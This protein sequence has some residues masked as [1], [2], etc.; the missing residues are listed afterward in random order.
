V[1][2]ILV[3]D[4]STTIGITVEW[5]LRDRGH[6]ILVV[7]DGLSALNALKAFDPD[8]VLLDIRLPR[9]NGF[10]LCALIR[11]YPCY[12]ALPIIMLSGLSNTADIQCALNA[13]ADDY[14]VKPIDDSVLVTAVERHLSRVGKA[15]PAAGNS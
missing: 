3:V 12:E 15:S 2:K 6:T 10:Q 9:V 4:D 8:L 5:V 7:S 14:L 1:A 13:G 11:E